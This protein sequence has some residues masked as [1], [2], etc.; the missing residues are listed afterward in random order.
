MYD[1]QII[2]SCFINGQTCQPVSILRSGYAFWPQSTLCYSEQ[3]KTLVKPLSTR[4]TQIKQ[5]KKKKSF[6]SGFSVRF[7]Y[8]QTGCVSV[9]LRAPPAY[10]VHLKKQHT[11]NIFP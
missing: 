3:R 2:V 11:R 6:F 4:S 5:Q 8:L 9:S 10:N 1:Y 7:I